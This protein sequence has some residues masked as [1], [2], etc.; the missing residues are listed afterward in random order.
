MTDAA[1]RRAGPGFTEGPVAGHVM[2]LSG[3]MILGFLAMTIGQLIEAVYLGQIGKAQLAAVAF[4]FPVTM[5]L[6][7]IARGIGA[8]AGALLA[9][10]A[11]ADDRAQIVRVTSHGL[12]LVVVFTTG[13]ALLAIALAPQIFSLL[14]ARD[15]ILELTVGYARLWLLAFPLFA[16]ALAGQ[17]LIRSLGDA[18]YPGLVMSSGPIVQVIVGPFLIF[19]WL[20]LPRLELT[21]AALAF[22]V[23]AGTQFLLAAAWLFRARVIALRP[24]RLLASV[25]AI[26]HVGIPAAGTN[27]IQPASTAVV[28]VLLAPHGAT[29]VAG[30]GVA[31]RIEAVVAMVAIGI[32][33]SVVPLVGQNWG[34]RQ[35][36]RVRAAM[37]FCYLAC[38]AWGL[39]AACIMWVGAPTFIGWINDDAE[40]VDTAALFLAIV[41]ISIG[42]M[43]MLNVANH[44]FNAV[45]R[46]MPAL[47]LSLTRLLAVYVPLALIGDH[48]FGFLGIFGA[49]AAANVLMGIVAWRWNAATLDSEQAALERQ[50]AA[51]G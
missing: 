17:G 47:I 45:R 23:G 31:S 27:L 28:T 49:I 50:P 29:V 39:V 20:G 46:P 32:S 3:F 26:L 34:A 18:R 41:P 22:A 7:A 11:G 13:L 38:L 48:F 36:D 16:V 24:E 6:N 12:T 42:F 14:G 51:A 8:G 44:C 35:F 9:Q 21:G 30:F 10:A 2:R 5:S 15:G 1:P 19:G 4:T 40:L 33:T 25:R 37:R 43:G